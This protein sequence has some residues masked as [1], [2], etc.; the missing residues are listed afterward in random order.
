VLRDG[1]WNIAMKWA[2]DN[3]IPN[4][5]DEKTYDPN[6][7]NWVNASDYNVAAA[8]YVAGKCE[9]R[10]VV[11]DGH[12]T[13]ETKKVCVN[14]IVTWTPG[15][16]TAATQKGGLVKVVSSKQYRSQMPAVILGP[17][18]FFADNRPETEALLAATFEGGDQIKA[19]DKAL[20]AAS[21]I[22]AKVY[23]DQDEAYWYK[24]FKGTVQ[25]DQQ[26]LTVELGGSAVNN[27]ADNLILFGLQPGCNDNLRSTYTVFA[28]IVS[29]Q[30]PGIVKQTPIPDVKEV[31]DKSYITGAQAK[32]S[33]SDTGVGAVADTPD[34]GQAAAGDVVSHRSYSIN[35]RTNS[36]ELTPQGVEQLNE[37]K[38][39]LAITGL[40]IRVDGY[41]DNT[42]DEQRTNLPLSEA[43]AT[44]VRSF[45]Q[46]AAPGNFPSKRFAVA[47]HGSANPVATNLTAE[48]K[49]A[50]RR[51]EITL[52]GN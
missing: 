36:A 25:K 48:G 20:H 31:E 22:S 19:F 8:D 13:G 30:Y 7:I 17:G 40:F 49:A 5:P 23:N 41:T 32:L 35:F 1:D 29:Q 3:N 42:G 24:Y 33:N 2:A 9:D 16:V 50:N 39:S 47:G 4:N 28:N 15:D 14:A 44:A 6:A 43:R 38:D 46:H 11:K 18:K 21:A 52:V 12:L 51:V 45:L 27:L 37:L 34:F 26:G 10:K